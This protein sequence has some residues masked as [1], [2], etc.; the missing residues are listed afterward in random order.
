MR[1]E[2]ELSRRKR[3][4]VRLTGGMVDISRPRRVNRLFRQPIAFWGQDFYNGFSKIKDV[5]RKPSA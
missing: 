4:I 3:Q 5:M 2:K 1:S